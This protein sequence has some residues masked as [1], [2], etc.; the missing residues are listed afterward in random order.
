MKIYEHPL[1]VEDIKGVSQLPLPWEKLRHS[2]IMISGATGL[3]G[4]FLIDVIMY[5]NRIDRL[6]CKVYS[7]GRNKGKAKERFDYCFDSADFQFV[8]CDVNNPLIIDDVEQI[9]YVIHMASNTH[10]M[11]YATD[12]IGTITT[13]I[14]GLKNMLDFSELHQAKRFAFASSNEIYGENRGDVEKFDESYCGYIDSNTMRAGYPESKRC[15]EALCQAYIAQKNMDIVIPRF[16][17]SY[18]PTLLTSDT[19]AMSQFLHKAIHN[20]DIIL[21][22]T[23]MQYYSYTYMA[24]AISGLL[25]ILLNGKKGEAY[26][27][28]DD[29]S[30]I[31]LKDL[32]ATIAGCVGKKVVFEIPDAVERAGYSK[33]TKARLDSTKLQSLGWNAQYTI[34]DGVKRTI[35]ILRDCIQK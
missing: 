19:K 8:P 35:E 4:S 34:Q 13:N 10:P 26:N 32:A 15:G 5:K 30:D 3:L 25:T 22:S 31:R 1:Y 17:R 29:K 28:A 23:G 21:K 11:A 24:D 18:G 9:G 2:S 27:I 7:L 20:E 33:A 14:Y 6:D 12:P 16:T